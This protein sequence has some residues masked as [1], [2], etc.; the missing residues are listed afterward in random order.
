MATQGAAESAVIDRLDRQILH[1]LQ[2]APR[3]P[4]ARLGAVV[5]VSE[6]T[7]ARRYQRM[8]GQSLI[9]VYGMA[10]PSRLPGTTSWALRITCRP[11]TATAT[12]EALARRTDTSWVSICAGGTELTCSAR[13]AEDGR[14]VSEGLLHHLPR[15]SNVLSLSAHQILHRF[16][17]RGEVDW[18]A[19]ADRLD[20]AQREHL[21]DGAEPD[22]RTLAGPG[23]ADDRR[24]AAWVGPEDRPLLAAL[25]LDGRAGYPALAAATGWTQRKVAL[26]L[27]ALT[28]SGAV[29]FDID[30]A[31]GLLGFRAVVN[32]WFSVAPAHLAAVGA[33]L[34]DHRQV[35]WAAAITGATNIRATALCRDAEEL[36]RYLTTEV[37]TIPEV[38][39]CETVP[40]LTRVKQA[41][42]LLDGDLLRGPVV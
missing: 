14:G 34:A 40:V 20:A 39:T 35:V 17:G 22:P 37:A 2:L 5:G 23:P 18:I 1:G 31:V 41:V 38:R 16:V 32:L 8:R 12:A 19:A 11:G 42:S 4:F 33:R 25:A 21:L 30:A 13:I 28:G 7:V 15:A 36:Y 24:P 9:R 3:V 29:W 27:A 26:R 10:D 6:Q